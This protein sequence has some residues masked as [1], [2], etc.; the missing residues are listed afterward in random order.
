MYGYPPVVVES[1]A[2]LRARLRYV[3]GSDG[4]RLSRSIE[5][6]AGKELDAIAEEFNLRRR[7]S[8]GTP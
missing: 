5:S 7:T 4:A 6:S 3:C 1:D 8:A 2:D